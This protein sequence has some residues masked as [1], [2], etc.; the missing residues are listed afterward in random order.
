MKTKTVF[1][2]LFAVALGRLTTS[3]DSQV[4]HERQ[5]RALYERGVQLRSQRLS[6][7]AAECFLQALPLAENGDDVVLTANIKDNLGAMYNKHQ[8]FQRF[9]GASAVAPGRHH[10][11]RI[12]DFLE[13]GDG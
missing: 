10:S 6:E 7:E 12:V 8:Q 4:K 2:I 9:C 1:L 11:N 13:I 3:C 5:A